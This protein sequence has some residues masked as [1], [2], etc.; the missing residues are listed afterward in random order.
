MLGP[1]SGYDPKTRTFSAAIEKWQSV[2]FPYR[3]AAEIGLPTEREG[4]LPYVMA[5]GTWW[6]HVMI[7]H[8]PPNSAGET[9]RLGTASFANSGAAI[10]QADFTRGLL[11]LHSFEY[12][13]AATA[14]RA[15][16]AKDPDFALAYWGEAMTHTHPIWNQQDLAAARA[17]LTRLGPTREARAAK[18]PTPR[19]RAWLDAVEQL[20]GEGPKERR[21]TLFA[22]AMEKVSKEYPDDEARAFLALATMG[23]SQGVRDVPSY[24]KAGAIA[25]DVFNRQPDHPG[26]AHY[27]IHAFDDPI[28]ASLGLN[29]ARAYS[30]IAPGA[31]HAQ[32]MTT[33]IF[34]AL[35]MWPEVISQNT[36][37]A[38][39][40]RR[41]QAG[42]YTYWRHYGLLQAGQLDSAAA[43]L[44]ELWTN[45]GPAPNPNRRVHLALARAQQVITGERWTDSTLG[46]QLELPN[47]WAN[48]RAVD[49]FARGYAALRRGDAPIATA[50]AGE[51]DALPV[52]PGLAA[53]PRLL[54]KELRASLARAAGKKADAEVLLREV[55]TGAAALPMEFGPPEFVKPP[56]ELLGEWLLED[57]R[58]TEAK[59]AFEA[60]LA[61]MP[62]RL[63]STLGLAAATRLIATAGGR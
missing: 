25:L 28:H 59:R 31:A 26:A 56:S 43:M 24:M 41:W 27:V 61:T 60:A 55:V 5:S 6:S 18:A 47:D 2:H 32:H 45:R 48:A 44:N 42:H 21:D 7:Q 19:E 14:F 10:A 33:H 40:R 30:E 29:A 50:I 52:G 9:P 63:R 53:T 54:A 20:Y 11:Y 46:W 37:A 15:A 23:L 58:A 22:A 34:L 12:E 49:G 16:Q 35:G 39:D 36:I 38:G 17:I 62:G 1:I 8:T 13:S 57:G 51:L 3:T 4:V